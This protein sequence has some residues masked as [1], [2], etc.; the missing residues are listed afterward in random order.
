MEKVSNFDRQE[1]KAINFGIIYGQ[2]PHGLSQSAE[3]PIK[4]REISSNNIFNHIQELKNS[5]I[6]VLLRHKKKAILTLF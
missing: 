3:F 6:I 2:G 4:K 5:L 1:A